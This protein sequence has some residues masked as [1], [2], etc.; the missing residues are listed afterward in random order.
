MKKLLFAS[1]IVFCLII[2]GCETRY[3]AVSITN[4]TSKTV[5]YTYNDI[6]DSL[7]AS[8]TKVYEV[9][10]YTQPPKDI[11]DQNGIASLILNQNSDS[12][13]FIDATPCQLNVLNN[14]PV[15]ITIKADN[16]IDNNN[17]MELEINANTTNTDAVI[18]TKNPNFTSVS[19]YPII[20]NWNITGNIMELLK[21]FV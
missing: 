2:L 7:S 3:Y 11:V 20:I 17:L 21:I 15:N 16:Y 18:Y 9:K 4:N 10:A 12:F 14:L 19:N 13:A 5:S 8:E 6:T 1:I